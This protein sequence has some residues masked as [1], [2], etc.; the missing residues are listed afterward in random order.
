MRIAICSDWMIGSNIL[1]QGFNVWFYNYI[2][3]SKVR[4]LWLVGNILDGRIAPEVLPANADFH[5]LFRSVP[6]IV[7]LGCIITVRWFPAYYDSFLLAPEYIDYR[8]RWLQN[9]IFSS[10]PTSCPN[11]SNFQFMITSLPKVYPSKLERLIFKLIK[12]DDKYYNGAVWLGEM[13]KWLGWASEIEKNTETKITG[14]VHAGS[15]PY[16]GNFNGIYVGCPGG[17]ENILLADVELP[18]ISALLKF[19]YPAHP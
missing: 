14:I 11:N 12:F 10:A 2:L 7:E 4:E 13:H 17:Y 5:R 6:S 3:N 16:W 9:I 15:P 19:T 18:Y 8:N 1:P